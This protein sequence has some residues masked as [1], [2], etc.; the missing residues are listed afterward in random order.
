MEQGP[1]SPF[2]G[3]LNSRRVSSRAICTL[4][5]MLPVRQNSKQAASKTKLQQETQQAKQAR[6]KTGNKQNT[7]NEQDRQQASRR[8][9]VRQA[10]HTTCTNNEWRE[11]S[12]SNKR[13]KQRSKQHRDTQQ[14]GQEASKTDN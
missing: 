10:A 5:R 7:S 1:H 6:S 3:A 13:D 14:I 11:V 9:H 8:H 12:Q 2:T 4:L